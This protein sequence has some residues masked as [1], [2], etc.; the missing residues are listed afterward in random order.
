MRG[1]MALPSNLQS[2]D[3]SYFGLFF[4]FSFPPDLTK[5]IEDSEG[6]CSI[7]TSKINIMNGINKP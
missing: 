4:F 2:D 5:T 6:T 1:R 7:R 3:Q